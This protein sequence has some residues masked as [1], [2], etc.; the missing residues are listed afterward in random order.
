MLVFDVVAVY[1][2]VVPEWIRR[3]V[4]EHKKVMIHR[5]GAWAM[6]DPKNIAYLD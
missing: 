6:V 1:D 3:N 2:R 4:I 5:A